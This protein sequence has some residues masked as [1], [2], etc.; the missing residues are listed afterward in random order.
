MT[1]SDERVVLEAK[2]TQVKERIEPKF[3]PVVDALVEE[4]MKIGYEEGM[5]SQDNQ[6]ALKL[7]QEIVS[8]NG[9]RGVLRVSFNVSDEEIQ[10]IRPEE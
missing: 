1:M 2:I 8:G 4:A 9:G 10:V 7:F 5:K 6:E 3:H